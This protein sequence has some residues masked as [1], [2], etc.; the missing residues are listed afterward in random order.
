MTIMLTTAALTFVISFALLVL[1]A[2]LDQWWHRHR[3]GRAKWPKAR[4]FRHLIEKR[5]S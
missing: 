5:T 4:L 1:V 3:H 2:L